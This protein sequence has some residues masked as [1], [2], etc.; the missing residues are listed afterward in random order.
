MSE[1]SERVIARRHTVALLVVAAYVTFFIAVGAIVTEYTG[2]SAD[3][4]F[5]EPGRWIGAHLFVAIF[6]PVWFLDLEVV[7]RGE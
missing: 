3:F 5:G 7:R 6:I 4:W 2:V 1:Q